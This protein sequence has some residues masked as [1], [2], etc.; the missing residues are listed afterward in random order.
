MLRMSSRGQPAVLCNCVEFR[1]SLIAVRVADCDTPGCSDRM[2][3]RDDE[4]LFRSIRR[5]VDT[6][7]PQDKYTDAQLREWMT[8][9]AY[10]IDEPGQ[11]RG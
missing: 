4:E 11:G 3:G 2:E 10:T 9:V 6:V 1:D 7:H 8:A 5:H